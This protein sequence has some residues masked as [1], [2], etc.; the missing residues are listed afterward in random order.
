MLKFKYSI[1]IP[2]YTALEEEFKRC[3]NSIKYQTKKPYEVICIDDFSP[4]ETPKI[5]IDYG[6]EYIRHEKNKQNGAARN[7]G[8][9]HASGDYL[10]FVNSDDYLRQDAIELIDKYNNGED[11]GLIGL[12]AFGILD[13][14]FV[15]NEENTSYISST[16]SM[17][18]E[19]MHI[20]SRKFIIDNELYEPEDVVLADAIWSPKVEKMCNSY[21][22]VPEKLYFYQNG[23]DNSLYTKVSKGELNNV[24]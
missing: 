6:F 18:G 5:V 1:I 3:L 24:F 23:Y 20:V 15:P 12:Q 17:Y 16:R 11:L 9:R 10:I 22:Y 13:F 21:F 8:I 19:P 4:V 7:T 2:C 14:D